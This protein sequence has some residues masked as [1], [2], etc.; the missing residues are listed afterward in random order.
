MHS[1]AKLCSLFLL[2][3]GLFLATQSG[4]GA[5]ADEPL[6]PEEI[7]LKIT[8]ADSDEARDAIQTAL[9]DISDLPGNHNTSMRW[10][11]GQPLTIKFGPV[12][13]PAKFA[14]RV[15][16]G[17]VDKIEDRTVFITYTQ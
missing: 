6:G 1:A 4:C 15:Q 17:K 14:E 11:T 9:E 16:F 3:F 12:A 10:A 5:P 7:R 13:D 2:A 8:G